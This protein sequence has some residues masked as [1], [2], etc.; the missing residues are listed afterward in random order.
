MAKCEDTMAKCEDTMATYE[1]QLTK[2]WQTS[3]LQQ[4]KALL[5]SAAA[6]LVKI[7]IGGSIWAL[8]DA[9]IKNN[10]FSPRSWLRW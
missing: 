2:K 7:M 10:W 3:Y 1:C 4:T 8:D 9:D 6:R 5:D